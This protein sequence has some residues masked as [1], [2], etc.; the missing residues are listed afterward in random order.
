MGLF[1]F[2]TDLL[3]DDH[4]G[5]S[6]PASGMAP[7]SSKADFSSDISETVVNPTTGFPMLSD[8]PAGIDVGGYLWCESPDIAG[9]FGDDGSYGVD[10]GSSFDSGSSFGSGMGDW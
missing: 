3:S 6:N 4:A 7:G 5:F 1:S 2:L 10:Y 8:S 9:S